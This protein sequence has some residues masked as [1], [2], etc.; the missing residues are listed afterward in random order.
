[1]RRVAGSLLCAL[2]LVA[3]ACAKEDSKPATA[4][5]PTPAAGG[6]TGRQTYTIDMD[7]PSPDGKQYQFSAFYPASVRARPGDTVVF[8]NRSE[9]AIHTVTFGVAADRS[10]QPALITGGDPNP[11]VFGPCYAASEPDPGMTAC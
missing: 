5:K 9:Q 6:V 10:N 3:G 8:A 4:G 1:M 7:H 11:V 2:V